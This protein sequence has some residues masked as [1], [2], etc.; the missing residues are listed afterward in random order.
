MFWTEITFTVH[1]LMRVWISVNLTRIG[2]L[3]ALG[4]LIILSSPTINIL[5]L[6]IVLSMMRMWLWSL[7]F[8]SAVSLFSLSQV[9][10]SGECISQ[11]EWAALYHVSHRKSIPE[12]LKAREEWAGRTSVSAL[13]LIWLEPVSMNEFSTFIYHLN[14]ASHHITTWS[15]Q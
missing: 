11:Q 12:S 3:E 13:S 6:V 15:S 14:S 7:S 10:W 9:M 5:L 1:N 2:F 8:L 4:V